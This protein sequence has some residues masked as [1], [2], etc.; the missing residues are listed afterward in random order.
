MREYGGTISSSLWVVIPVDRPHCKSWMI[1]GDAVGFDNPRCKSCM[2]AEG[3]LGYGLC[4]LERDSFISVN[5]PFVS[6]SELC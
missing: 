6:E 4:G 1:I 3:V 5:S 2:I